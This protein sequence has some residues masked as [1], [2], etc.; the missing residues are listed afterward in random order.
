[1][2]ANVIYDISVGIRDRYT[3]FHSS[4]HSFDEFI[5]IIHKHYD[6]P[7]HRL[8]DADTIEI[9]E[10]FSNPGINMTISNVINLECG[11]LKCVDNFLIG[12]VNGDS[13]FI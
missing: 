6:S 5:D 2:K 11:L 10:N 1:M 7:M 13:R 9:K 3:C 8:R 12:V 4:V